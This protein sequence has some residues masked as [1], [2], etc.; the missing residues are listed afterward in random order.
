LEASAHDADAA[1]TQALDAALVRLEESVGGDPDFVAELIGDF[2]DGLPGQL[3]TLRSAQSSGDA[4]QM[5]RI[6]HTLKSNASTFGAEELALAC[7]ALEQAAAGG[8][9][10]ETQ[11]LVA[12]VEVQAAL[13]VPPLASA[14]DQRVP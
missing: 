1:A 14:R 8:T 10:S 6:A 9:G 11:E 2:L 7:R 3:D 5:H 13:V 4:Q 12:R